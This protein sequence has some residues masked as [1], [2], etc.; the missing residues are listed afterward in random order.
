[1]SDDIR[2]YLQTVCKLLFAVDLYEFFLDFHRLVTFIEDDSYKL[3]TL[4]RRLNDMW[5]NLR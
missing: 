3:V 5:Y 1:M 2:L 4:L